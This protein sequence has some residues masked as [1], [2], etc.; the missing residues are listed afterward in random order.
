MQNS[1]I[2]LAEWVTSNK[3]TDMER[4]KF[5]QITGISGLTFSGLMPLLSCTENAPNFEEELKQ[6]AL[7]AFQRFEEVWDFNDFWKRGNTFDACLV[8]AHAVHQHWSNDPQ[9]IQMN[10]K[11]VKMLEKIWRF[12]KGLKLKLCGPMILAG[13][14]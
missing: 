9:V 1:Q 11:I 4:R 12:L 14:D 13:G 3:K 8:F 6:Q 5:I 2:G 10:D 7:L